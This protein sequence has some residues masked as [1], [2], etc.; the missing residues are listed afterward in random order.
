MPPKSII[1]EL[2]S[3]ARI[4]DLAALKL[5]LISFMKTYPQYKDFAEDIQLLA[6][7]FR[8]NDIKQRLHL[9][10]EESTQNDND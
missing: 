6:T 3:Y 9:D 2:K 7:E 4:G 5:Y 10:H 8:L 1:L